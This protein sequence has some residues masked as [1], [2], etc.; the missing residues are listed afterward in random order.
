MSTLVRWDP[1]G[2]LTTLRSRMN[3]LF[4]EVFRPEEAPV[5]PGWWPA[6]DV[7][8]DEN[9]YAVVAELPGL[10]AEDI[11]LHLENGHLVLSGE[12]KF[13]HED[14]RGNYHRI[15]RAYGRFSRSFA[16]PA[17]VDRDKVRAEYREGILTVHLPKAEAVKPKEIA[18]ETA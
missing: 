11:H 1:F 13:E 8:E 7:R 16:V 5:H 18:V 6:A 4:D 10:K 3:R 9:E 17:T 15:E 12:R 2:E 14:K